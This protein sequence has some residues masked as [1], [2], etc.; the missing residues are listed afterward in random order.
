M[1]QWGNYNEKVG[2]ILKKV[3][4]EINSSTKPNRKK[5]QNLLLELVIRLHYAP[6]MGKRAI[7]GYVNNLFTCTTTS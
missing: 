6:F 3:I 7:L 2:S 4:E 5:S 1:N